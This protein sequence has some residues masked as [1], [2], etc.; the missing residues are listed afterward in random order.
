MN[1]IQPVKQKLRMRY[2]RWNRQFSLSKRQQF[3][4]ITLLST[5]GLLLTQLSTVDFR[6]PILAFLAI[7][8]YAL[9]AF[10]L[11]EDLKS[12][13]WITLLTL[14]S[15][16]T[17]AIAIFYFLLPERWLTRIPV[18]VLYAIGMYALLL[19]ENIYNVAANRTIALL[20]AAHSVGFLL[21]LVT[22]FLLEQS[23]LISRRP[24]LWNMIWTGVLA[25]PLY[26]QFLWTTELS[27]RITSRVLSL[28]FISTIILIELIWILSFWPVNTT[29]SA[30]F[31]TTVFYAAAGMG[32]QYLMDKLYKRTVLEFT[33]LVL[34]VFVLVMFGTR[35]RGLS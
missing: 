6:Y 7:I 22:F 10:A 14:P 13:E 25:Y 15:L 16:F 18:A 20:R 31:L 35:W 32:Q 1:I 17:V 12:A 5:L 33:I 24:I 9:T 3:V 30:L 4:I 29:I 26:L 28:S 27:D 8:V 2:K 19:T 11:R 34:I 21:T 23:V